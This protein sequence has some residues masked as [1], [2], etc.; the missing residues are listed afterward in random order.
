MR[1][2]RFKSGK[3][4]G[5]GLITHNQV[6]QLAE[7]PFSN[8]FDP[9]KAKLKPEKYKLEEV[10]LLAPC[11]PSK[12]VCLGVN[13]RP[14]ANEMGSELPR[15]PLI[16]IKPSTAVI[17]PDAPIVLPRGWNRVDYEAELAIVIGKKAK[18]VSEEEARQYV[19]G[20]TCFND[21]TERTVQKADG[22][23]TRGKGYDTFA[24]LGPWIETELKPDD[25]KLECYLNGA[26]KQ[27][28]R[29]SELVFGISRLISFISGVMTLLPG[30]VIATGTPSGIGGMKSGDVV[31][32]KIEEIGTLRNPV[33]EP[34]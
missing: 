23:W 32:I 12:V 1:I 8:K 19:L 27:S 13:Y 9:G 5:Y 4:T 34:E 11:R 25:L 15:Q 17:G 10:V 3:K 20:Y 6:R 24:P 2:V 33:L 22:Q 31:E 28:G 7:N 26:L 21:V 29:T 14:H 16:F 30:D 18:Y